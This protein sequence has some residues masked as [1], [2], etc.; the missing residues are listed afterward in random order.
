MRTFDVP[1]G[2]TFFGSGRILC[3]GTGGSAE[4]R[5]R[6]ACLSGVIGKAIQ[7][8]EVAESLAKGEGEVRNVIASLAMERQSPRGR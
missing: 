6:V 1:L 8:K 7:S 2:P 4:E 5:R 3:I